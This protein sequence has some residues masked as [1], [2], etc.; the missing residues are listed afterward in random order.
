MTLIDKTLLATGTGLFFGTT[1]WLW[2]E[3]GEAVFINR[4]L[5]FVQSCL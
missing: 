2:A 5:A 3:T 1:F 4:A